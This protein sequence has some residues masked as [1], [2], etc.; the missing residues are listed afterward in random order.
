M[1]LSLLR[2][3]E[4]VEMGD[5][6]DS[7][8]A[9]PGTA[10]PQSTPERLMSSA[11]RD[12]LEHL[13]QGAPEEEPRDA[14][15][16]PR[17]PPPPLL[18]ASAADNNDTPTLDLCHAVAA[19]Q[20]DAAAQL[21]RRL[22]SDEGEGLLVLRCNQFWPLLARAVELSL[23]GADAAP[24]LQCLEAVAEQPLCAAVLCAQLDSAMARTAERAVVAD[25][26]EGLARCGAPAL[27]LALLLAGMCEAHHAP[28]VLRP[29][30]EE[31]VSAATDAPLFDAATARA[32][33]YALAAVPRLH[34]RGAV[35]LAAR[36]HWPEVLYVLR[37]SDA[38][39]RGHV[40]RAL[41]EAGLAA[42]R[43]ALSNV[44]SYGLTPVR[45]AA[46]QEAYGAA[47]AAHQQRLREWAHAD[48]A[49]V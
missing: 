49:G 37:K 29:L 15:R 30:A 36:G 48:G 35:H 23:H 2:S 8:T 41:D 43:A 10:W 5:G 3:V 47:S 16:T 18:F 22:R 27:P 14:M 32:L 20:R 46:L 24:V 38:A 31:M 44:W 34:G 4:M 19:G 1:R 42:V 33:A 28:C 11:H 26:A 13:A 9:S 17:L 21:L 12:L 40:L 25:V 7:T 39:S 45:L 6:V